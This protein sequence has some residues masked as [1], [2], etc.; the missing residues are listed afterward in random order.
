[1]V[2]DTNAWLGAWPFRYLAVDTADA[3]ELL[4]EEEGVDQALVCSLEAV[5]GD[6][7]DQANAIHGR[8][9]AGHR[10]LQPV[11]TLN[12]L[13]GNAQE[14]LARCRG[15]GVPAVRLMPSFHG[16]E[17]SHPSMLALVEAVAVQ[18][19]VVLTLQVRME[20]KRNQHPRVDVPALPA[21]EIVALAH[22]FP[23]TPMVALCA[24][25]S[26]AERLGRETGNVMVDLSHVESMRTVSTLLR[27]VPS[28]RVLL[29]T[30]APLLTA[31][32]A[33]LKLQAADVPPEARAA[34][35]AGNARRLF[36]MGPVDTGNRTG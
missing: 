6:D 29:G 32:S 15:E 13:L 30:H 3:L 17:L 1:M 24:Y 34:I 9:L 23:E 7:L 14:S 27:H 20:D 21:E 28:N 25:R 12:P 10:R 16:Y 5:F 11:Y 2:I 22:R 18:A 36:G 26:E 33:I 19:E 4:M 31:R 8:R 35:A